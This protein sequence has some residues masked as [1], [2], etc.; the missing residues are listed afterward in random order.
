MQLKLKRTFFKKGGNQVLLVP[1]LL[2]FCLLLT[3]VTLEAQ[4]KNISGKV[5]D[6][7]F[8]PLVGVTVRVQGTPLVVATDLSGQYTI[9]AA[10]G[11]I[12]EF[13]YIGMET[14]LITVGSSSII[15]VVL[16]EDAVALD[17]TVVIGYG[18]AKK[19][20]LT[21][22]IVSIKGETVADKP[23]TN[24]LASIQGRIAGVQVTNTGRAGQDPEIRIRGTNSING[25]TPLYV[26]DG[27]FSDNINYLN[28]ADVES[29]EIL[30]D[31][32]SLAIFGVRGANGVIII[33]TKKAKEGQT[34]VNVNSSIG[35]KYIAE[36]LP[37]TNAAQ[38]KELYNEQRVNQGVGPF[39]YT[40]WN[41]DTDWQDEIFQTG[42]INNNNIS[43]TSATAKSKFYAGI[44]Y[45][46]EQGSIKTE[47]MTK[48]TL[49]LNSEHKVKDYLKVGFQVNGSRTLPPDAKGVTGV[50]KAAPISPT[51]FD[52]IDPITGVSERLLHTLPDFQRAQASNPLRDIELLGQHNIGVN[53]RIAGN[54]FGEVNFLQHF[55]FK[56]TYSANYSTGESRSF[57]P[58]IWEYN[59][60]IA[61][62]DKKTHVNDRESVSQSKNTSLTVQ[63]DYI[64]TYDNTF[65]KHGLTAMFGVTTNYREYSSLSGGRSQLL[66]DIYFSP[67]GNQDKWWLSALPNTA[68]TNGSSQWKRFT[69]SYLARALY[70]YDNRYLL[71]V[72]YRRDGSSVFSGVGNTW[73]DFYSLGAGWIVSGEEFMQTQNIINY[74]KLKG[75]WGV[76]GSENT[77]GNN[78]PTY[79]TL[80]SS[81]SAVFGDEIIPGYTYSYLVQNLH[82]EKTYSWEL[83]FEMRL[84][85]N[86]LSVEPVYYSKTTKDIIVSLAS[87]T[88]ARNS[89]ENLGEINNKG[90]ELAASWSDKLANGDFRY[91]IGANL[92]TIKN[93]VISL[94]RDEADAKYEHENVSRT[95]SG[96]P[97][98]HFYGY[99]VEGVYQNQS[100]IRQSPIN[101]LANVKPGDLKFKDIDGDGRITD[102]DR[103][104]IGNP[105]PD[106]LYGFNINLGYKNFDLT[107][108]MM[109]VYGNEI[110]RDWG[111]STY[112]Q[113]NYKQRQLNRW[114]G[115]GTS[116]WE[117]ILDPSRSINNLPSTYFIEDG[118]FFRIR[119]IQLSYTF[120]KETLS[121][122]HLNTVRIF[123]N[124]QNLKTWHKNSGYT[125]EVGGGSLSFGIDSGGYPMPVVY[126]M[127]I[128]ISF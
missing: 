29:M 109:G 23:S 38:F 94:G 39:D 56:V 119:N 72:S 12:L 116:N 40:N 22:S 88:G 64:L 34:V 5:T 126:T 49:N 7:S 70:N 24:P 57:S 122:I 36:R 54:I 21:G 99:T 78:Y 69:M 45:T 81:G 120:N 124:V 33:T 27:L 98:A 35:F 47:K 6:K 71:N 105:T 18:S 73:D 113:L 53:H 108:D 13:S 11:N 77:G 100:D 97:I 14:Q 83:G 62:T 79:P 63:Q 68:Q 75:S 46:T 59:P 86:R 17:E 52:Y 25:Y 128:N 80:T 101:T 51:H 67:D 74:L 26:V 16:E 102:K 1:V 55:T 104:M 37:M 66:D 114:H 60:D 31:A 76:L 123:A 91:S 42:F 4:N 19:R 48:I 115:E 110:Y 127:G 2:L 85:Q 82:W 9:S 93:N 84:L 89:L 41:A 103:S 87:R 92:T 58:I 8:Y 65:G 125:P 107:I 96:Y 121:K 3:S 111:A 90:F 44:G 106:C 118:S 10:L 20:D 117:P 43:I 95:L 32:S 15:D 28:S 61:G 112:A 30:K 50:L